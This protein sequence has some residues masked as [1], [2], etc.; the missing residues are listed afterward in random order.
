MPPGLTADWALWG[1]E[2]GTNSGY[3]VLAACPRERSAEFN[4]SVHHWSPGTPARGDQLP[5]I[6]I[7]PGRAPDGT[8]TVGVFLLDGTGTVDRTN[9]PIYRI[10]HFAVD[11]A[12][13]GELGLS[14]HTCS[15]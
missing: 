13:V 11:A 1:K 5:W 12:T 8:D 2:P 10:V 9:R 14:W 7:G 6:T 4:T 3:Q 15:S